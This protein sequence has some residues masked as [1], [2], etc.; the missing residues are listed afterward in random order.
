MPGEFWRFEP[1]IFTFLCL[2]M[3]ALGAIASARFISDGAS[4]VSRRFTFT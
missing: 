2:L 3:L 1:A 4:P